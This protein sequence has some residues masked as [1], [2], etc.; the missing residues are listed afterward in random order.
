MI[1]NYDLI[2]MISCKHVLHF[3]NRSKSYASGA[4][5]TLLS[6]STKENLLKHKQTLSFSTTSPCKSDNVRAA[7]FTKPRPIVTFHNWVY[8]KL[9]QGYF[10]SEFNLD[11]FCSNCP[12]VV[13]QILKCLANNDME[14]LDDAV[15]SSCFEKIK[16]EWDQ[17]SEESKLFLS[18]L[19]H[20]EFFHRY[21]TIRIRMPQRNDPSKELT[22]F[23]NIQIQIYYFDNSKDMLSK[24]KDILPRLDVPIEEIELPVYHNFE[25]EREITRGVDDSWKLLSCGNFP[26]AKY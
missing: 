1:L 2:Q 20:T 24:M 14:F 6:C 8:C 5:S 25:F 9:I 11:E 16:S 12:Y 23:L 19:D 10:D 21:P 13:E 22:T 26:S 15:E 18:R 3:L 17:L 7:V 4:T